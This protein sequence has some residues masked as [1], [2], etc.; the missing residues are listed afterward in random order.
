MA[1]SI[2]IYSKYLYMCMGENCPVPRVSHTLK[3]ELKNGILES[4][5]GHHFAVLLFVLQY[6]LEEKLFL[7]VA[8]GK[9]NLHTKVRKIKKN[10]TNKILL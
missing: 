1:I 9:K 8:L 5:L 7:M 4:L 10:Q 2:V 6:F 3:T